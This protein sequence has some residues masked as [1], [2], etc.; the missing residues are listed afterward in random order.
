VAKKPVVQI[1]KH[2]R[3]L[4]GAIFA[5]LFASVGTY[6]I[7]SSFA[8]TGDVANIWV[9]QNGGSCQRSTT[10]ISY[11][12]SGDTTSCSSLQTACNAAASGDLV[13]IRSGTNYDFG[14]SNCHKTSMTTFRVPDDQDVTMGTFD[15]DSVDW[16]TIDGGPQMA[17]HT[18]TQD[19][20]PSVFSKCANHLTL[21]HIEINGAGHDGDGMQI[22]WP[23]DCTS[24]YLKVDHSLFYGL[25]FK[26]DN[27]T[28]CIQTASSLSSLIIDSNRLMQ[29]GDG[30]MQFTDGPDWGAYASFT[31]LQNV[32]VT[33]NWI[34]NKINYGF[35]NAGSG[36][37]T[38]QNNTYF[39]NSSTQF[40]NV[41]N[42][43]IYGNIFYW[44]QNYDCTLAAQGGILGGTADFKYN[45]TNV[46][47]PAGTNTT[48]LSSSISSL[49]VNM[50]ASPEQN[51]DLHLVNGTNQAIGKV[52]SGYYA[53][54]DM[55]GD[56]RSGAFADA[57][58]DEFGGTGGGITANIW[59]D[60]NGGSCTYSQPAAAYTDA[61][62]CSSMQAAAAATATY[63][64]GLTTKTATTA[65]MKAGSY[66]AQTITS[67]MT[68]ATALKITAEDGTN[69][70][71]SL[72][73]QGDWITVE[74]VHA[75]GGGFSDVGGGHPFNV[76]WNDI[77]ISGGV[78]FI[79]G[80][81]NFLWHGGALHDNSTNNEGHMVMQGIPPSCAQGSSQC[82]SDLSNVTIDSVDFYNLTRN[83]ACIQSSCHN[84]II[85]IDNG[86]HDITVKNSKF[87]N[88]NDPNSA[89]IFGGDKGFG[90]DEY[91]MKFQQNFFG[92]SGAAYYTFDTG[93]CSGLAFEY[94][95]FAGSHPHFG[96]ET[97]TTVSVKGNIGTHPAGCSGTSAS[98][99]WD[100]NVWSDG[101]CGGTDIG[102]ANL[103]FAS[104]G[105][106]ILGTSAAVNNGA[107]S[108]L[109]TDIDGDARPQSGACD[110]GA[111]E[112]AATGGGTGS[113]PT[114]TTIPAISGT[115]RVSSVLTSS[116]GSWNN[117]PTSYSYQWQRCD[118]SGANCVNISGGTSSTFTLTCTDYKKTLKVAVKATNSSG[119]AT[120]TSNATAAIQKPSSPKPGDFNDDCFIDAADISQFISGWR[121]PV[122]T[123]PTLDIT[124][125][126]NTPDSFIDSWD[127][128][129]LV[130]GY[131]YKG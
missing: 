36:D 97:A 59:I 21:S 84:E 13:L 108:C 99:T 95:T 8:A 7:M 46:D 83:A 89:I 67:N 121:K 49:F 112:I 120:A 34:N 18:Q 50:G 62:A 54:T 39:G 43:K 128:Q 31:G 64:A 14:I 57:G 35:G 10:Q 24:S 3:P 60:T 75:I 94:N 65:I 115:T 52:A 29:C 68:Q 47:C 17:L 55:D 9:D 113:A 22:G 1:A 70:T 100:H 20:V 86:A 45:V 130:T 37:L 71:G 78:I 103:G 38:F 11:T 91:N 56:A 92:S 51:K 107:S 73:T 118:S 48:K 125:P 19:S 81:T 63:E 66:P 44:Y 23:N 111:D 87:E 104:D 58:A 4:Y 15:I 76:T 119:N 122:A 41:S 42:Q 129:L 27:H 74:N 25:L 123:Y 117:S 98:V 5:V 131:G 30:A 85:R 88:N 12:G 79:D 126:S 61:A 82:T 96:C 16:I 101:A 105:F 80:G 93:K 114:N 6:V 106:H 102:N 33:N 127:L 32:K 110:A 2:V 116:Q 28:D 90:A 109:A 26:N 77:D 72:T 124:G 69:L 53:A 40:N